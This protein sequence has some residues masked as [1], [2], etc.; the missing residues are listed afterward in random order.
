[1]WSLGPGT[2]GFELCMYLQL[3]LCCYS[4]GVPSCA[5]ALLNSREV[6]GHL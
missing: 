4:K 3:F 6:R 2:K 1:M 5:R